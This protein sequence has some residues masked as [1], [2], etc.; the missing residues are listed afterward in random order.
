MSHIENVTP[1][2]YKKDVLAIELIDTAENIFDR[3]VFSDENDV[4]YEDD[5]YKNQHREYYMEDINSDLQWY[6]RCYREIKNKLHINNDKPDI[7]ADR[8][9]EEYRSQLQ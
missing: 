7:V 5:E 4:I 1:Y 2:L 8:I 9:V 3:L 6:G